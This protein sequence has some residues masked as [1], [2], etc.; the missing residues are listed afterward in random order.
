VNDRSTAVLARF[1]RGLGMD[2]VIRERIESSIDA[3][4]R[5]I[6]DGFGKADRTIPCRLRP[7]LRGAPVM[8][9]CFTASAGES[10]GQRVGFQKGET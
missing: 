6:V 8:G 1:Y 10:K 3:R 4:A 5:G 2:A 9:N 7:S